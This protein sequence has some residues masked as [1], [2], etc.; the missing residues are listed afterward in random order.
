MFSSILQLGVLAKTGVMDRRTLEL[1]LIGLPSILAG[2]ALGT[3]CARR[4]STE[5]FR[6]LVWQLLLVLGANCIWQAIGT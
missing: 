3:V 4:V 1:A 5:R 2:V 6:V